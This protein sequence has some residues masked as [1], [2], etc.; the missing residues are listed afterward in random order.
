MAA[1]SSSGNLVVWK[2]DNGDYKVLL[3]SV[4]P[5]LCLVI[6]RSI[7]HPRSE[8]D[9]D[10]YDDDAIIEVVERFYEQLIA[11]DTIEQ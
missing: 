11:G 10:I 7:I 3:K 6:K 8:D 9:S 1:T 4:T 5:N 2:D